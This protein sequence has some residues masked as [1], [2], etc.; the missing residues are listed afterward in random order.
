MSNSEI[1][2]DLGTLSRCHIRPLIELNDQ[3]NVLTAGE[4]TINSTRIVVA[5]DQSHGKTSLLEAL[6]GIDL[7]RGEGIQ[8][9]V[10]LVLQLRS[11]CKEA[12]DEENE[13][14]EDYALIKMASSTTQPERISLSVVAAKVNEYTNNAAGVGK[15]IHDEPIELKVYR[16][17]QVDLTLIDLPGIT[18]V[19]VRDQAGGWQKTRGVYS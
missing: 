14:Q 1:D 12:N 9:R 13:K 7:P 6:G 17:G 4:R 8:T 16:K 18:R 11:L 10:P 2:T 15:D 3:V 5:G 19:A